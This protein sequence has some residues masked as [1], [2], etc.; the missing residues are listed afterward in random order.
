MSD[1]PESATRRG[2]VR[3]QRRYEATA[4][5]L[6]AA[7]TEPESVS[8]WLGRVV[9]LEPREGGTYELRFAADPSTTM[10]GRVRAYEPQRLLE[11]EWRLPGEPDSLVRFELH[12]EA[13]GVRL[14]IDHRGLERAAS[15]AYGAGWQR[16]L[17]QLETMF[18]PKE[19]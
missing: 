13:E 7:L 15:T 16:H 5:E 3:V 9:R 8:R 10:S 2:G 1:R 4:A 18:P 11:L 6:W 17:D 14:V 12:V 19:E